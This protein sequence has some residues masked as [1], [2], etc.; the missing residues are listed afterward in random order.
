MHIAG[1]TP[2]SFV[3]YPDGIAA[4][5]F[6]SGCNLDCWYCHNK[7]LIDSGAVYYEDD[8]LKRI[9]KHKGMLDG[10]VITGGEP[11]LENTEEL[12][13][14]INRIKAIGLKVKLDTNG[15]HPERLIKLLP[16]LDYVAMDVKAP[17][18]KY[19]VFT[20]ISDKEITAMKESVKL[21]LENIDCEFRTTF[22]PPLI[23]E[24]ILEIAASI[25]GCKH[26]Y[27]QQYVPTEHCK[28]TL[29]HPSSYLVE[30]SN[31]L[32]SNGYPC[33]IRGI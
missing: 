17:F 14:F 11:T 20:R 16:Y 7:G 25:R 32:R 5:V 1:F 33:E 6:V 22:A 21:I 24:D 27:L 9:E 8:I 13:V 10:V 15:T 29:A 23:K 26:Y 2:N 4:V 3:D 18:E 28:E 30:T 12:I 31:L 19:N